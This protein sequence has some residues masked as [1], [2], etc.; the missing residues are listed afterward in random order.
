MQM[1]GPIST[2]FCSDKCRRSE[3]GDVGELE[4]AVRLVEEVGWSEV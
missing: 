3:E 4:R 1:G 2:I